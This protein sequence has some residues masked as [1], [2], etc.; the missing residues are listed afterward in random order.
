MRQ[1]DPA[2]R[3]VSLVGFVSVVLAGAVPGKLQAGGHG[4]AGQPHC[5]QTQAL[6]RY[7]HYQPGSS[8]MPPPE[9]SNQKT[10]S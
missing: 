2:R 4:R 5:E 3:N 8:D 7:T 1:P 10:L 6:D 9:K